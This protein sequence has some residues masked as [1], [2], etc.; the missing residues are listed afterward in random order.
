MKTYID[1]SGSIVTLKITGRLNALSSDEFNAIITEQISAGKYHFIFDCSELEYISSA[2]IRVLFMLI[3]RLQQHDGRIVISSPN[4]NL[5]Q[6]FDMIDLT[7][8]LAIV[9]TLE[10]GIAV[11]Q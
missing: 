7:K 10:E 1:D 3:K 8:H 9:D 11:F 4:K 5:L 2:G 6:I